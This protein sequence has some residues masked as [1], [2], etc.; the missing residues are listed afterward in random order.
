MKKI[1]THLL[2]VLSIA[3]AATAF[4]SSAQSTLYTFTNKVDTNWFNAA[5]WSPNGIPGLQDT[6]LI[7]NGSVGITESAT[8]GNLNLSGGTLSAPFGLAIVLGGDWTGGVLHGKVTVEGSAAFY[9]NK[10]GGTLDMPETTLVNFGTVQW[11]G[12]TIR[13]DGATVITNSGTWFINGVNDQ[14]NNAYGGTPSFIN[15][16]SGSFFVQNTAAQTATFSGVA[17][18]NNYNVDDAV[19]VASGTL[20]FKGGGYLNGGFHAEAGALI[21]FDQV[22][23]APAP[24]TTGPNF[25]CTGPGTTA[26][27]G[28]AMTLG[29]DQAGLALTGGTVAL[30]PN[31]QSSGAITN[32]TL[33]GSDL[34]GTNNLVGTMNWLAGA[35][36]GGFVISSSG[37][38]NLS[39]AGQVTQYASLTNSG[40]I[41]WNGSGNWRLYNDGS[42]NLGQINNLPGGVIDAQCN[43]AMLYQYGAEWFSNSGLLRKTMST[44]TTTI[45][46]AFTNTA[47]GTVSVESGV[48]VFSFAGGSFGGNF[49]AANGTTLRFNNGGVLS[50]SFTAGFGADIGFDS[51]TFSESAPAFGGAGTVELNGGTLMLQN[52][53]NPNLQLNGGA[54]NLPPDFQGGVI[55][56]LT[57][58]GVTLNGTNTVTGVLNLNGSLSGPLTVAPGGVV[59]WSGGTMS[60]GLTIS[61]GGVLNLAGQNFMNVVGLT[62]AGTINWMGGYLRLFSGSTFYNLAGAVFNI[63]CDNYYIYYGSG[64]ETI[65]NAGLVQK[66]GTTGLS[67]IYVNLIN[68]GVVVAQSGTLVFDPYYYGQTGV[69]GGTFLAASGATLEFQQG[70]N[71]TGSFTSAAGGQIELTSGTFTPGPTLV[72]NGP[73]ANTMTGGTITLTNTTIPNL[74]LAGGT[75]L[76]APTFQGGT[77]TSLALNGASIEGTNTVTGVLSLSGNVEGPLTVASN[78][79]LN[80]GG[81]ILANLILLPGATLNWSNG[82]A[83]APVTIFSNAVVNLVGPG[84]V[85]LYAPMTNAGTVNWFGGYL[86]IYSYHYDGYNGTFY[87][88]AGATFNINLQ[89]NDVYSYGGGPFENAGLLRKWMSPATVQFGFALDNTGLV[90]VQTGTLQVTGPIQNSNVSGTYQAEAGATLNFSGGGYLTG[91]FT[92]QGGG[93]MDFSGG[94]FTNTTSTVLDGVGTYNLDGGTLNLLYGFP[95]NLQLLSGDINP[96][97]NFQ[98]GSI[99]NLTL[100]GLGIA[101]SNLVTG[102]LN[103]RGDVAGPL[104][105]ASGATL[106]VSGNITALVTL[107][108][109]ATFNWSGQYLN[110]PVTVAAGAV[111]NLAPTNYALVEALVTNAGTINWTG[112]YLQ[113][114][115]ENYYYYYYNGSIYNLAGAAFN[116]LTDQPIYGA[117]GY[118]FIE[119]DGTFRKSGTSGVNNIQVLFTNTG[120]IDV[121]SGALEFAKPVSQ[122]GGTWDIGLGGFM[123]FNA[124]APLPNA[125]NVTASPAYIPGVSNF[126]NIVDYPS[127][128]GSISTVSLPSDGASWQLN[129]GNTAL[130]LIVTNQ[131]LPDVTLTNPANNAAFTAPAT[132]PLAAVETAA[133]ILGGFGGNGAGWTVNQSPDSDEGPSISG[134]VLHLTHGNYYEGGSAFYSIPQNVST[135]TASFTYHNSTPYDGP[136]P[137]DGFAFVVQ[138]DGP[139]AVGDYGGN[140]GFG[141]SPGVSP[142]AAIAFNLYTGYGAGTKYANNAMD[143]VFSGYQSVSPVNLASTDPL[144]VTISYDGSR[145]TE[146][147]VDTVTGA[148]F[149]NAY[150]VNLVSDAGGGTAYVGFSGGTGAGVSVQDISNFSFSSSTQNNDVLAS[151]QFYEGTTLVGPGVLQGQSYDY[152][153]TSV[154]VGNYVLTAVATDASG[155]TATSAPVNI[156]VYAPGQQPTNYTWT[157]AS[158]A[159]WFNAAN[160]SPNGVPGGRDSVLIA[161]GG[162]A[163]VG[164]STGV[165]NVTLSSGTI[166]GS[167]TLTVSNLFTWLGGAISNTLAIPANATLVIN[168]FNNAILTNGTVVNQGTVQWIHGDITVG[169]GT[170]IT[171][172]SGALCLFQT[173]NPFPQGNPAAS[174]SGL[175]VNNGTVRKTTTTGTTSLSRLNFI[176][177]GVV[178]AE[179]GTI[180]FDSGGTLSGVYNTAAGATIRFNG[181]A[182]TLDTLASPPNF[183]GLGADLFSGGTLTMLHDVAPRLQLTGGSVLLAT[184]FQQG[185]ITNLTLAGST[186]LGTNTVT[187]TFNCASGA[188]SVGVLTVAPAGLL[189]VGSSNNYG[190]VSL[191]NLN[192]INLGEVL[193]QGGYIYVGGSA[194]TNNNLWLMQGGYYLYGGRFVNN[195]LIKQ[196]SASTSYIASTVFINNGTVDAEAGTIYLESGGTFLG[197]YNS[198]AGATIAFGGGTNTLVGLPNFTGLGSFLFDGGTLLLTNDI[199]PALQ[200]TGG[201]V[202]LGPAFQNGGAI[203][204]LVIN[205]STLAGTNT[206]TGSL[207]FTGGSI[208][209]PLTV[210]NNATLNFGTGY[211]YVYGTGAITNFGSVFC[212]GNSSYIYPQVA[213]VFLVNNGLWLDQGTSGFSGYQTGTFI[214]NGIYRKEGSTETTYFDLPFLNNG[215]CDIR[216]GSVDFEDGGVLGGTFNV[217][218]L[219]DLYLY[220]GGF[221]NGVPPANFT[222]AGS[223]QFD[224][225]ITLTD[226]VIPTLPLTG[227]TVRLGPNFQ[228]KGA[229]TNLTLSGAT[230]AGTNSV[231]GTLNLGPGSQVSGSLTVLTNGLLTIAGTG[232]VTFG[233]GSVLVN[234]GVVDWTGGE[235]YTYPATVITNFGLWLVETDNQFY[236]EDYYYGSPNTPFLNP[237]TFAK[238]TTT[239]ATT[240]YG[241]AFLNSGTLDI[242]SG[243]LN[244]ATPSYNTNSV[245]YAQT[246]ATLE[247]GVSAPNLAGQLILSTN[248]SLDGTLGLNLL[249]GWTPELGDE[250]PVVTYGAASQTAFA[251]LV[252]PPLTGMTWDVEAGSSGVKLRVV[253]SVAATTSFQISGAVR[254]A[255]NNPISGLTV[256]AT[257]TGVTNLIQNGSF[258]APPVSANMGAGYSLYASGA[259]NVTGWTVVGPA[260]DNIAIHFNNYLGPAEDGTQYFDPTGQTGGAG[261]SQTFAT[262]PGMTYE[263][264]FYHGSYQHY[265]SN[266]VL[267]V[268]IGTNYYYTFGETDGTYDNLDWRRVQIPFT[269][270]SGQTTLTFSELTGFNADDS[271]VDNVQVIP[272]G[273]GTV[274]QATT[275][276]NGNYQIANV[277]SGTFQVGVDGLPNA[278]YNNVQEQAALLN[279]DHLIA[280]VNFTPTPLA[281]GQFFAITTSVNPPALGT[282]SG[283]GTDFLLGAPVT[284]SVTQNASALPY[285]FAG[286]MENGVLES[287]NVNYSF[288]AFRNRNLVA[289]FALPGLLVTASNNPPAD[290]VVSGAGLYTYNTTS[291]L[292]AFPVTGY[293]FVDWTQNGVVVGANNSLSTLVLS[294]ITLVANYADAN[295][296]HVVTIASAPTNLTTGTGAGTY[297]NGQTAIITAPPALTNAG[298]FYVFQGFTLGGSPVTSATSFSKSFSTFDPT[299]LAYVADYQAFGL[300]PRIINVNDN[301][302]NPV[303]AT[304]G[305]LLTFQF[306]RSMK[307][308]PAPLVVLTNS[309]ANAVQARVGANGLWSTTAISNDTYQT[310]GITFGNGMDGN[311]KVFVSRVQDIYGHA[312]SPPTNV[313]N[314]VVHSTPPPP[315]AVAITSP[316]SGALLNANQS[317]FIR[318]TA[319]SATNTISTVQLYAN[320]VS[321]GVLSAP[322]SP[323]AFPVSAGL[324]GGSYALQAVAVDTGGLSAT[325]AVVHVTVN[326]PGS[327]LIDFE[328][329]NASAGPVGGTTLSNYLAGFG[330]KATNVTPGTSLV[331]ANDGVFLGGDVVQASSGVNFLAQTGANGAVSYTLLFA[332]PYASVSWVRTELLA[333]STGASLPAWQAHIFDSQGNVLGSA[334]ENALGSFTNVPEAHFTLLGQDAMHN[335]ATNI[336]AIRFD[337]NNQGASSLSTLPLDDLLLATMATNTTLAVTLTN[338]GG[339]SFPAPA[340]VTLNA[341]VTDSL[342]TVSQVSFYEGSNFVSAV[343]LSGG[344]ASLTLNNLAAGSYVFT[345]VASDSLGAVS[346]SSPLSIMVTPVPGVNVINFDQLNTSAGSVGGAALSN[347]LA[348]FGVTLS[349]VTVGS[350]M[351]A[352][353]GGLVTGSGGAVASSPPN[354]F[355]QAGLSQPVSF[356]LVFKTPLQTFGFTRVELLAGAGGVS[357]PQWTAT[358]L[359]ANGTPLGSAGESLIIS[360]TNVPARSFVLTG[361][362]KDGIASVRFDS[363]SQKTAAFSA[364][365]L[366]DLTLNTNAVT[367]PLSVSLTTSLPPNFTPPAPATITLSANVTDNLGANYSVSFYA[368]PNLVGS[369]SASPYTYPWN[370]VLAGTYVLRAQVADSS[371]VT[372][373][374]SA[375]TITVGAGGSSQVVNFDSLNATKGPVTNGVL[376]NYLAG[377]GITATNVSPGTALAVENQ[378]AINAGRA[379]AASSP[380]NIVTQI[381]SSGP[382][383]YTVS[384][385]ALLTNFGFTRPELLANPFVSHPAWQATAFDAAGV[386]LGQ[387]GEGL[388]GSYTNVGAQAFILSGPGIASVQ[389]ASQG[390]GLTTF[391]ALVADDFV[392]TTN[393]PGANF[394]P[395]VA[396]TSPATGLQ[397][398]SPVTLTVAAQAVDAAGIASVSFYANGSL[399]ATAASSPYSVQWV[400]PGVGGYALTAVALDNNGLSRTSPVVNVSVLPSEFV[401]GIITQPVGQTAKVGSSVTFSVATTGTGAVTYQWYQGTTPLAGQ[402]E[403]T[404]TLFPVNSTDAGSYT[405]TA[406]SGGVTLTSTPA[407]LTVAQPP[408]ITTQ[409]LGQT[410]PIGA[411]VTLSPLASGDGPFFWQWLLNGASI[412][413]ATNRTYSILSAQP[414]NSG[415]FQVQ[416]SNLV[417]FV[418]S[419]PAVVLVH[420]GNGTLQTAD[421]FSNRISINPLLGPVMGNNQNA[422][423]ETG[424]TNQIAGKTAGKSI[425]YTWQASFTGVISLTTQGSDFDTLLGVY[426]GT[427]VAKL[428]TVAADDDSGGYL[429]SLVTFNVT[430]GTNYQIAVAGYNGESGNVVLG[431]PSGTGYRVLPPSSGNSVPV[432]TKQP[433]NQLAQAGANVT[434]SV[435]A[436]SQTPM[437]YQW[438]FQGAP[439]GVGG[440][441]SSL[442]ITNFQAGSVGFYEVLVANA[443]GSVLS[444][445]ASLQIVGAPNQPG[446]GGS[447]QLKF[448]DAVAAAGSAPKP[449]SARVPA[450]GG[451][452]SRGYSVS[453]VF[454]TVGATK[455]PGEPAHCGQAG[456]ASEWF[457]Y[458]APTNGT[459]NVNTA[460]SSFNTI[461]AIYTGPGTNFAS[462][463]PQGCGFVTNY[464]TQ[465]QPNVVIPGVVKNTRFF[466]AVDGYQGASGTVQLHIGL[467]QSPSVVS[468]PASQLVA[469]GSNAT[470]SVTAIG[471]TNFGYQWQLNGVKIA[472]ATNSSYTVTNATSANAGSYIVVVSNV[473]ATVTSAPPAT[474]TLQTNPAII[475]QPASQTVFLGQKAG[476]AVAVVGVN[477]K[478]NPLRY[479]WFLTN[480]S[481]GAALPKATNSTLPFPVAQYTNNGSYFVTITNS[482][483]ATNS[484]VVALT[485]VDTNRPTVAFTSPVNNFSTNGGVVTLTGTA[486]DPYLAVTNVQVEVNQNGFQTATGTTKWTNVVTLVP[487]TNV[488]S[489]RS[490][491][492]AGTNSLT[493]TLHLIYLASSPLIVQTNGVGKVTSLSGATNGAKLMIGRNY[494]ILATSVS[495]YLFTNWTS[496]ANPGPLTNFPGGSNLTFMMYTNMVLQANFVPNPFLAVAGVYSGLFYPV[497][498]VTEASSG[499]VSATISSNSTGAYS[500]KLLLKGGSNS[501]SGSFDLTGRAQT[502]FTIA[503]QNVSVVL[504]LDF[505]PAD[506][507]MG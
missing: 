483:G 110:A 287:T 484:S 46:V 371:G 194:I 173:D 259:T 416:V 502:N 157:G 221:T 29:N 233:S 460:G 409:P 78:A 424:E 43:N 160:W 19:Y 322:S 469:P 445:Q 198:E 280:T 505:N 489:A 245:P 438:F 232:S 463:I 436:S 498:G 491:N 313:I 82:F 374:S 430:A 219:S 391:N 199:D 88:L 74:Q 55:T 226:D 129:T 465:G 48:M 214:N 180:A 455:E 256:Y 179:S 153:W 190:S 189:V 292:T 28:G 420:S 114:Y 320:G 450:S 481:T 443:V 456:G 398:I 137:A 401:F 6:A 467:G 283:G 208:N 172:G 453:Q 444:E 159:N 154:P 174:P 339:S 474:L 213:G 22:P 255:N 296:S 310:P 425:W 61:P 107:Q 128:S 306:D 468:P 499:F 289:N 435:T 240:F 288:T 103:L 92:A 290:G 440:T 388:I 478:A 81:D 162:T 312:L 495:N 452:D 413:G 449:S 270:S 242:E 486:A 267:G 350:A 102:V 185:S 410:V 377:F 237:G 446:S 366:D 257:Q 217:A 448:G 323:Y 95:A 71:L 52:D 277:S 402:T 69:L 209:G 390:S 246:G 272:P 248:V 140:L 375:V 471:S 84:T 83:E 50:G 4:N 475:M 479:Q 150:A 459:L 408:V 379:V 400:N 195:G 132:I 75:V 236:N 218:A 138:N 230:L 301:Y 490:F 314:L 243:S 501:F 356:T 7:T 269:A 284:V 165:T 442:V 432:I 329:L 372:A 149:T 344:A 51:G 40:H 487:G 8:V 439:V 254:D 300:Q 286:W 21:R 309:A 146:I 386:A 470:F 341:T 119:N 433:T 343:A 139:W 496:G 427:N 362:N 91:E 252:L 238:T 200:L 41:V 212:T 80:L 184:N 414:L 477:S 423:L 207:T 125:L 503:G 457:V 367:P 324:A 123:T 215:L 389:F 454:S 234:Q 143:Y 1:K 53:I 476:F 64:P 206:V 131:P 258:E 428:T 472:R 384:F 506:A 437:T 482:F 295:P 62:N 183:T 59:N 89:N 369:V 333:G 447:A 345:A 419:A 321:L 336:V 186:L 5:N 429:T 352:V 101:G 302:P 98:G 431:M 451:G 415:S 488:I 73:G 169:P 134:N 335:L 318:G 464:R 37:V 141:G 253:P 45:D 229:I 307:V 334:G 57:V 99:S 203:S 406:T 67:S 85:E 152:A 411:N 111:W 223:V 354:Y 163:V 205:G 182:F 247:F 387:V 327:T 355:T 16:T 228:L 319:T 27:T 260:N 426:T 275:D 178:D 166:G 403:S 358:I 49:Q 133:S 441:G 235:I 26:L 156:T 108:P 227:G 13:G 337:G 176:N 493:N 188:L 17:F 317:F 294:N 167:G 304:T 65:N 285:F 293:K 407:V 392:L 262:S 25:R 175:F 305:F 507:L 130:S 303:P 405:V 299:S 281:G 117:Y 297:T 24:F 382:V 197:A 23:G 421:Y 70:G 273:L 373:F 122:T 109:G 42:A 177:N 473:V 315:P 422:T 380:P 376:S 97:P 399:I 145:L 216:T 263:L 353:N 105:V 47:T 276:A 381:G 500:A 325:S 279:S 225:T 412:P 115:N 249:N 264:V 112:G 30:G 142:G 359:D 365:L 404:L 282:A 2:F 120:T 364:V 76:L 148:G 144:N 136:D 72:F 116:V 418:Q 266:A 480:S 492:L 56:N 58:S 396:I 385:A 161:N 9:L 393:G 202:V 397:V 494:T 211:L 39:G 265:G 332:Q 192:L 106:S 261:L 395:A 79:T 239:G 96:G 86:Y 104:N 224:G 368:G 94:D 18:T 158:D 241:I 113:L 383:S 100:T 497:T 349:N 357:H 193:W 60:G 466:I 204:H 118:E 485:V 461:L 363:D 15:V 35:V 164:H 187:G 170:I 126:I 31:F 271:F 291:V 191:F 181:G 147:L 348:G 63:E 12:G 36:S 298:I 394:P 66:V 14:F 87:N 155:N 93:T 11:E 220:G 311:V 340:Q 250:I 278:G 222:G 33:D 274:A 32:L 135:F 121:E 38:L 458:T 378:A 434:L 168:P 34:T 77:I 346:S 20:L 10:P 338:T 201:T 330:V 328:A 360:A 417:A 370:N 231:S 504:S 331:A 54:I 361:L 462:L 316:A 68:T 44:N 351:E 244:F 268:T 196:T 3:L 171:N 151:V 210:N 127:Y 347:Y 124:T 308:N 90:D 251:N 342:G 326:N